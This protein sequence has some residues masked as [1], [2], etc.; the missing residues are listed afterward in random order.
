MQEA[1]S[2][3]SD[4][5]PPSIEKGREMDTKLNTERRKEAQRRLS[6]FGP[7][8]GL[9]ERRINIERRLF[10]FGVDSAGGW[11]VVTTS[12]G[13]RGNSTTGC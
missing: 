2:A 10:N 13:S 8:E 4:L 6:D 5:T 3:W 11:G 1:I 7:P 9:T 12:S